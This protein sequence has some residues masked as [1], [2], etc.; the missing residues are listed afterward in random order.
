MQ[1][2][3]ISAARLSGLDQHLESIEQEKRAKPD[4]PWNICSQTGHSVHPD[5]I[6]RAYDNQGTLAAFEKSWTEKVKRETQPAADF[7]ATV[8]FD[9]PFD[10]EIPAELTDN[11]RYLLEM[12]RLALRFEDHDDDS[13]VVLQFQ[14]GDCRRYC[15]A[16]H[17]LHLERGD[18]EAEI[19]HMHVRDAYAPDEP[20]SLPLVLT[21]SSES[22][23]GA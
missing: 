19:M 5:I 22:G 7:P 18:F 4:G 6:S 23:H 12:I 2:R 15:F 9:G 16:A 13:G 20:D 11:C 14:H 17:S 21:F 8:E 10:R 3:K 1:R